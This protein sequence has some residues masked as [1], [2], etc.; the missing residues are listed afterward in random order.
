MRMHPPHFH[1]TWRIGKALMPHPLMPPSQ[2]VCRVQ[3]SLLGF[4]YQTIC[5]SQPP[6][7]HLPQ[8]SDDLFTRLSSAP[9][10]GLLRDFNDLHLPCQR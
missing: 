10:G 5:Y 1:H 8:D 4:M 2:L 7:Q 3:F 9:D 6:P